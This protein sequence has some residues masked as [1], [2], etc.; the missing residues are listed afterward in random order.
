M[1]I[2]A[3]IQPIKY[4]SNSRNSISITPFD[5]AIF[6][7]EKKYGVFGFNGKDIHLLKVY[8]CLTKAI[9]HADLI[10]QCALKLC[11]LSQLSKCLF[12]QFYW[13][14]A[15]PTNQWAIKYDYAEARGFNFRLNNGLTTL[16]N[17][18]TEEESQADIYFINSVE[19][20]EF[21]ELIA[22]CY[23]HQEAVILSSI[24]N[25]VINPVVQ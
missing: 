4:N 5:E 21:V 10:N 19:S 23:S 14:S 7:S 12:D 24:I 20:G 25:F 16:E 11:S 15:T 22:T 3:S 13:L 9:G 18:S 2:F 17:V 8:S 1:Y 6:A